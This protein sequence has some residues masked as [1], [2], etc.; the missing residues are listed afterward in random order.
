M[1][2]RAD[3]QDVIRFDGTDDR[4]K[5]ARRGPHSVGWP[6]RK[7]ARDLFEQVAQV[8]GVELETSGVQATR[9]IETRPDATL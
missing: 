5:D 1:F 2:V 3:A 4:S 6:T 8:A 7:R 9:S